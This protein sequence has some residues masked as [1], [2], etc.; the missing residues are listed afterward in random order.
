MTYLKI[1]AAVVVLG[2][3]TYLGVT[4]PEYIP[5]KPG[6][7]PQG[8]TFFTRRT[9]EV[10]TTILT[11][12]GT[13]TSILNTDANTR[14]ITSGHAGCQTL[15]SSLGGNGTAGIANLILKAATTSTSAPADVSSFANFNVNM[16]IAT[17]TAAASYQSTTTPPVLGDTGRLWPS[18]SYET[19]WVNATNTATCTFGVDWIPT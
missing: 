16:T 13:T 15:S 19:F 2:T 4:Y 10:A 1:I 18:G 11:T 17:T 6:A 9:S 8:S 7:S 12:S 5:A 3:I 14:I